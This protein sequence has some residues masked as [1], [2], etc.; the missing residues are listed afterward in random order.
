MSI[1]PSSVKTLFS[2][3]SSVDD[4]LVQSYIDI[5]INYVNLSF[6]GS[7]RFDFIHSLMTAHLM[8]LNGADS[9]S[10]ASGPVSSERLGDISVSY[11]VNSVNQSDFSST[12]YG[13]QII[14]LRRSIIKTPLVY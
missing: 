1:T 12:K 13:A 4:S 8:K 11:A 7:S 5:A 9:S 2:E 10:T 14:Q 3:F 6:W